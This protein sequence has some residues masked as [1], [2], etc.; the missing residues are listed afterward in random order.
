VGGFDDEAELGDLLVIGQGVALHGRG[1][2]GQADLLQR[3]DLFL[4]SR[5][6]FRFS[7]RK[8]R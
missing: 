4:G 7:Y 5:A 6:G 1:K 3:G 8:R 2:A